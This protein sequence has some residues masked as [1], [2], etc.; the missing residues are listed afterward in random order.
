MSLF[1]VHL[2]NCDDGRGEQIAF[3]DADSHDLAL[4]IA[5]QIE[6]GR[7]WCAE[8]CEAG[9]VT[10][11]VHSLDDLMGLWKCL[12]PIRANGGPCY[13]ESRSL[14]CQG[15]RKLRDETGETEAR[16]FS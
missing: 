4:A 2:D 7:A 15:C 14:Y 12:N 8:P 3:V 11:D 9:E 5:E 6:A 10:R 16:R 1:R 13:W